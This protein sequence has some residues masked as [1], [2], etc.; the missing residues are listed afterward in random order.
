MDGLCSRG[1]EMNAYTILAQNLEGTRQFV[2]KRRS[3][4]VIKENGY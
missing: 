2:S 3:K 4:V 1:G